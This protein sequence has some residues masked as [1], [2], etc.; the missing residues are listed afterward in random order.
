LKKAY[1][2]LG[3][4]E[5]VAEKFGTA[6]TTIGNWLREYDLIE[7]RWER[8]K[9]ESIQDV[10]R[11]TKSQEAVAKRFGVHITTVVRWMQWYDI[12]VV[13]E[14]L[15]STPKRPYRGGWEKIA[16]EI[17]NRD[18]SCRRCGVDYENTL[19]VHHIIP[20]REFET[21]EK[22]HNTNNLVAL[23][24]TCHAKMERLTEAEQ[25]KIYNE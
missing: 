10:Y 7:P 13:Y 6:T 1:N 11:E 20:V 24:P 4:I 22:A 23:C 12:P 14:T 25:R 5:S 9:K 17:R 3:T 18:G 21:H 19:Q 8:P 2:E 16:Q 15:E